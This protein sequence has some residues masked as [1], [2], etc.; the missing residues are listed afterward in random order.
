M[1]KWLNG[2]VIGALSAALF[3][4][5]MVEYIVKS[6]PETERKQEPRTLNRKRH[7]SYWWKEEPDKKEDKQ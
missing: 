4:K 3:G 1:L 7:I 5:I 6:I 2:F